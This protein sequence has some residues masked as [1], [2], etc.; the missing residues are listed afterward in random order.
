MKKTFKNIKKTAK[1]LVN[2][3]LESDLANI[4]DFRI[5]IFTLL[6]YIFI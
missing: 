5:D 1:Q 6:H 2:I 4:K 3:G